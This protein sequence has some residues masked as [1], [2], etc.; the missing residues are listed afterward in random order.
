MATGASM[1]FVVLAWSKIYSPQYTLWVLPLLVLVVV[2]GWLVAV[3]LVIDS[4]LWIAA[5]AVGYPAI[6]VH[7][8]SVMV[9]YGVWARTIVLL[10]LT[11]Y[12]VRSPAE[13][14]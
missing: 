1:V 4:A 9:E 8:S 3:Y 10:V 14:I 12:A 7:S 11:F 5:F 6:T 13:S 2:P